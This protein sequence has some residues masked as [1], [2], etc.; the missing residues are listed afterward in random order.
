[1]L[2]IQLP[3][4]SCARLYL[5]LKIFLEAPYN[6]YGMV[7][8]AGMSDEQSLVIYCKSLFIQWGVI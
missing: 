5:I 2:D 4:R 1:M 6:E 8:T 3:C 7:I